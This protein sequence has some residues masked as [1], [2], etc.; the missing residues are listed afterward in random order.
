M[1][2]LIMNNL[3]INEVTN[4]KTI[5][6]DTIK[7][8]QQKY[9]KLS[10]VLILVFTAAGLFTPLI[11]DMKNQILTSISSI[12]FVIMTMSTFPTM[13]T[14]LGVLEKKVKNTKFSE[15]SIASLFIKSANHTDVNFLTILVVLSIV[16][17]ALLFVANVIFPA[18]MFIW[19]ITFIGLITL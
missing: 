12:S 18:G 14:L 3:N 11:I 13:F 5:F 10:I 7:E 19:L 2:T 1:K 8:L 15:K 17:L 9:T 6:A 16:Y 4:M